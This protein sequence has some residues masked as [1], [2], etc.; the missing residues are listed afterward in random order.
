MAPWSHS[1]PPGSAHRPLATVQPMEAGIRVV[2]ADD[3]RP[4]RELLEL[5]FSLLDDV[6]MIG[7]ACTGPEAVDL[8]ADLRPDVLVL[9]LSIPGFDGHAVIDQVRRRAPEVAVLVL[10]GSA[11]LDARER[12]LEAGATA[13]LVK[14]PNVIGA[15]IETIRAIGRQDRDGES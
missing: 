15:V 4:L 6:S 11:T 2:V 8:V 13:C 9:D 7:Q 10:T 12:A 3:F 1:P 5:R 14:T